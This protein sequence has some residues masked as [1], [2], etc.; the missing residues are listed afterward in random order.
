MQKLDAA[1]RE[2]ILNAAKQRLR[3]YGIQKTTMQEIAKDVGIAGWQASC[4]G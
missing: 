2:A 1:K 3:Q 4:R